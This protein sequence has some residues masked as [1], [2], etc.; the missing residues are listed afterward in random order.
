MK[1]KLIVVIAMLEAA[2]MA[3]ALLHIAPSE[4]RVARTYTF[5]NQSDGFRYFLSS[6]VGSSWL[7]VSVMDPEIKW[8]GPREGTRRVLARDKKVLEYRIHHARKTLPHKVIASLLGRSDW[9]YWEELTLD[10]SDAEAKAINDAQ[11]R[12][13][14]RYSWSRAVDENERE[15]SFDEIIGTKDSLPRPSPKSPY[16]RDF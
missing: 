12:G 13:K 11:C 3:G 16:P 15:I 5:V 8:Y 7:R 10:V 2:M 9:E 14:V 6:P 4:S 1:Q